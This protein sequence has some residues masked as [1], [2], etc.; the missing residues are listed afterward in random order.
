MLLI[1]LSQTQILAAIVVTKEVR[2]DLYRQCCCFEAFH[3]RR[4]GEVKI[5]VHHAPW[6]TQGCYVLLVGL[7]SSILRQR[8]AAPSG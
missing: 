5:E 4:R 1:L 7:V 6:T 2:K 8:P 3:R